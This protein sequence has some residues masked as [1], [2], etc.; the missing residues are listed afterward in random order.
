MSIGSCQFSLLNTCIMWRGATGGETQQTL[1][2]YSV[3]LLTGY[4]SHVET[5][6]SSHMQSLSSLG[7]A[8][9]TACCAALHAHSRGSSCSGCPTEMHHPFPTIFCSTLCHAMHQVTQLESRMWVLTPHPWTCSFHLNIFQSV[10]T[11]TDLVVILTS[12]T[13]MTT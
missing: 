4:L 1:E 5:S 13:K 3:S 11:T 9:P 10:L 8:H 12:L 6:C 7:L 2:W